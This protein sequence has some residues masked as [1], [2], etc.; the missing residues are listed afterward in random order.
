MYK[1]LY[2]LYSSSEISNYTNWKLCLAVN[3]AFNGSLSKTILNI[4]E[5]NEVIGM[6]WSSAHFFF[7]GKV[8]LAPKHKFSYLILVCVIYSCAIMYLMSN[9]STFCS[10]PGGFH[11]R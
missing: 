7:F 1:R 10:V 8:W 6:P 4:P 3:G 9:Y 11:G 2:G 5:V